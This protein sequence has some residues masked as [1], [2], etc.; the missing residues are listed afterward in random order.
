MSF[1]SLNED[2][3]TEPV[4]SSNPYLFLVN[5]VA[6]SLAHRIDES[7]IKRVRESFLIMVLLE[8]EGQCG[9]RVP[10]GLNF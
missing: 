7:D 8:R 10:E 9:C 2:S 6:S 5:I 3:L 1:R 4:F